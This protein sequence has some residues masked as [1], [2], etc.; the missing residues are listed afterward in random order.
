MFRFL[1]RAFQA[2]PV[3]YVVVETIHLAGLGLTISL[4]NDAWF[5]EADNTRPRKKL[6]VTGVFVL[7]LLWAV[8]AGTALDD[9]LIRPPDPKLAPLSLFNRELD[10]LF[11]DNSD[12][13]PFARDLLITKYRFAYF[14]LQKDDYITAL[15]ELGELNSGSWPGFVTVKNNLAIVYVR[16]YKNWS[17]IEILLVEAVDLAQ[18]RPK[19][20]ENLIDEN[21]FLIRLQRGEL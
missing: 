21:N 20:I 8:Y 5:K 2:N 19:E 4:I 18:E 10:H 13:E 1:T 6:I 3:I 12:L 17:D 16:Q 15:V 9:V 11:P 7:L 14:A